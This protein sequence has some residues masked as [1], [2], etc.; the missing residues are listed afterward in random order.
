M[1]TRAQLEIPDGPPVMAVL[2]P[3]ASYEFADGDEVWFGF[4]PENGILFD[5]STE[6]RLV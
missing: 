6:A 5:E 2:P 3:Q 4:E 1:W